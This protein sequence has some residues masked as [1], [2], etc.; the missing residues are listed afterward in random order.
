[1][2]IAAE[3]RWSENRLLTA[4]SARDR[5]RLLPHLELLTLL[6]TELVYDADQEVTHI[7]FPLDCVVAMISS[8][9]PGGSVEVGLTGREGVVGAPILLGAKTSITRIVAL[10]GGSALRLP[11]AFL[12]KEA[13]RSSTL[14]DVV[15]GY[16]HALLTQSSQL[17][18]C[19]R[20][21]SAEAR[22]T[23]VLLTAC[24]SIASD[25]LKVTHHFLACLL[26]TRRATVTEAA[27]SLD[28]KLLLESGRGRIRVRDR[29]G[30]EQHACNCYRAITHGL[31]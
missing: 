15:L 18:A 8:A 1:M 24:D 5:A 6:P 9:A 13:K 19:H 29:K 7:Y 22:L 31:H 21:H 14:R 25:E 23:R 17:A 10:C 26:G 28:K 20:Y 30:L 12:Q 4:M 2:R 27:N 16:A 11:A 3:E